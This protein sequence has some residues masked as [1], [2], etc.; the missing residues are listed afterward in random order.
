MSTETQQAHFRF[1]GV[2]HL[3]LSPL[4]VRKTATDVGIEQLADLINAEGVLQN[5]DVY[6]SAPRASEVLEALTAPLRNRGHVPEVI[7]ASLGTC[8]PALKM[9]VGRSGWS[10]CSP[11]DS[12]AACDHRGTRNLPTGTDR[13]ISQLGTA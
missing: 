5:L 1:I 10:L 2:Q 3:S 13:R 7:S 4:N 12:A 9:T 6:E 8:E 11:M